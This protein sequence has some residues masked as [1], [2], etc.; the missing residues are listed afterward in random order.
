MN[1]TVES[2]VIVMKKMMY[3]AILVVSLLVN[4]M[5]ISYKTQEDII[6][7]EL[8]DKLD[9]ANRLIE[10]CIEADDT[11]YDTVAEGDTYQEWIDSLN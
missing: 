2:T 9:I 5:F 7:I 10:E 11:F 8:R 1:D 6:I 3:F 4:I